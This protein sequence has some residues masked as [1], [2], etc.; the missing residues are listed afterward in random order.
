MR[1]S[2]KKRHRRYLAD[3]F[4]E[5]LEQAFRQLEAHDYTYLLIYNY[6]ALEDQFSPVSVGLYREMGHSLGLEGWPEAQS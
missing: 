5:L 4:R 2:E 1:R 6:N 3:Q